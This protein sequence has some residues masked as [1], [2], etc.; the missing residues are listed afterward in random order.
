M[1]NQ[2]TPRQHKILWATVRSYIETAEPVGSKALADHYNLGVSTATIR[3][4][5][6]LLEQVGLLIQ[7][8]VSAGRVPSDSGYRVYVDNLLQMEAE[9]SWQELAHQ[10]DTLEQ[11]LGDDLDNLLTGAARILAR[12]SGCIAL[13]TA[14]RTRALLIRHLQLMMV[15]PERVLVLVV[16]DS[17]QTHSVVVN[18]GGDPHSEESG[19]AWIPLSSEATAQL[20]NELQLLSNFLTLKLRGKT[21]GDLQDLSW[22]ELDQDFRAYS[23]WLQH[24]LGAVAQRC[25]KPSVGQMFTSGVTELIRQPEFAYSQQVQGIVQLLEEQ[26][27][28]LTQVLGSQSRRPIIVYIGTENP[29][30]PIRHCTLITSTYYRDQEPM[31]TVSLIGPTR[32]PYDQAF[33]SVRAVTTRLGQT[34][35]P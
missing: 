2:L 11:F 1:N 15:D 27:D 19:E 28:D 20:E 16:A 21:F 8:H 3:N 35:Q 14:P 10:M 4:D 25:L 5:L 6:A 34:L 33:S 23:T 22:L 7:P 9:G 30:E 26:P 32:M 18:L 29:L 17:Y 13:V 12:L 31:G 24:L